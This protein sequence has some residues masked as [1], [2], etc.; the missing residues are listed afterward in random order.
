MSEQSDGTFVW[1]GTKVVNRM[2]R[3][4]L[5]HVISYQDGYYVVKYI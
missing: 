3:V 2:C 4:V 1:S 5:R